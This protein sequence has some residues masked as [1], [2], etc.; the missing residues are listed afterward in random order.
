MPTEA[1]SRAVRPA[2]AVTAA[3]MAP[4]TSSRGSST[5]G[6]SDEVWPFSKVVSAVVRAV[7]AGRTLLDERTLTRRR[8]AHPDPTSSLTAS[9]SKVLDLVATGMT[10]RDIADELGLAEKLGLRARGESP[11]DTGAQD[12]GPTR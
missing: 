3:I 11:D 1:M 6:R 8:Q 2:L 4:I 5:V 7:A 9:E 12:V 10:N